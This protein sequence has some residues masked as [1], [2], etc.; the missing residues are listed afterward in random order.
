MVSVWSLGAGGSW[1][2]LL[3]DGCAQGV[4]D[5][6]TMMKA[7]LKFLVRVYNVLTNSRTLFGLVV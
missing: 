7:H 6:M 1:R 2:G 5:D 3:H 4:V